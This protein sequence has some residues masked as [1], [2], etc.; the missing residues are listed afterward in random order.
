MADQ[1]TALKAAAADIAVVVLFVVLGR[2]SHREGGSYLTE[3]LTVLAPFAL[4]LAITWVA[5]Q[6]WKRPLA[7]FPTGLVLWLGTAAGGL[8][9]RRFV[10]DR[11]TAIAFVIVGSVFLLALPGWRLLAEWWRDRSTK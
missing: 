11:S 7:S 8:L 5:S 10:F 9:L 6:A 4:A 2:A 3:T 1:R